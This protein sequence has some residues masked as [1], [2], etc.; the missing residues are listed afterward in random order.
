MSQIVRGV[1]ALRKGGPVELIDVM[2]PQPG[3]HD[4][5]VRVQACGV[6]HTGLAYRE[7]D[8]T[9]EFPFPGHQLGQRGS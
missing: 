8:I 9:D 2:V 5:V 4:V 1:V 6:C 7:G 3:P